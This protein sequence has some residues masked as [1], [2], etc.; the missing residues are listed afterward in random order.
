[1]G[2]DVATIVAIFAAVAAVSSAISDRKANHIAKISVSLS[3][4]FDVRSHARSP[5][6]YDIRM[7]VR[8]N[9]T[10]SVMINQ[11]HAR[12][13]WIKWRRV[14]NVEVHNAEWFYQGHSEWCGYFFTEP[15]DD[16]VSPGEPKTYDLVLFKRSRKS[17]PRAVLLM[18]V[19]EEFARPGKR[20]RHFQLCRLR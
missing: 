13:R 3:F 18:V 6:I 8:N 19:Y 7:V 1:M 16:A 10:S 2:W 5:N 11:V 12:N 9:A 17:F 14:K 20:K 4:D 15:V